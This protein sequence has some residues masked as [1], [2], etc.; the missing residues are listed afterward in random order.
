MF[1]SIQC[2]IAL[3]LFLFIIL[4]GL[5]FWPADNDVGGKI[6]LFS[7]VRSA[8]ICTPIFFA[9]LNVL[10]WILLFFS[11]LLVDW[12]FTRTNRSFGILIRES[13]GANSDDLSWEDSKNNVSKKLQ[14]IT[15]ITINFKKSFQ[16][17]IIPSLCLASVLKHRKV[18]KYYTCRCIWNFRIH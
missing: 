16:L 15:T 17:N 1:G 18:I 4:F 13:T 14:P 11:S 10:A 12:Q 6:V 7:I 8:W 9:G 3:S 2:S 5:D